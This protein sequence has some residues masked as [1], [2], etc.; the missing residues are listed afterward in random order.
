MQACSFPHLQSFSLNTTLYPT[1]LY[2]MKV[3]SNISCYVVLTKYNFT[4]PLESICSFLSFTLPSSYAL[5][6]TLISECDC[7][8]LQGFTKAVRI[9]TSNCLLV[10]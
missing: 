5:F 2:R 6:Q 3:P 1:L 10:S 7:T 8:Q 4:L 9:E